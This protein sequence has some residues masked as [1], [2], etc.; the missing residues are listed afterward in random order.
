MTYICVGNLTILGSDN[1]N[2]CWNIVDWILR[3]KLRRNFKR[4]IFS[5]KK[6]NL[7]VSSAKRR[8]RCL[9]LSVIWY[10]H[11][12]SR[13]YD[14][15]YNIQYKPH[16]KS[17]RGPFQYGYTLIPVWISK[18]T[19]S[20]LR[21]EITYPSPNFNGCIVDVWEMISKF[22]SHFI[23]NLIAYPC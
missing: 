6:I 5:F 8:P 10:A 13:P 11:T 21:Y 16:P 2:Q 4:N 9:G 19:H 17:V 22:I 1:L 3:N 20:K 15:V 23:M 7:N 14:G 12:V 18:H